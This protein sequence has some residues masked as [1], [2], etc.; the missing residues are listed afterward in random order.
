MIITSLLLFNL[1]Y[2]LYLLYYIYI[3]EPISKYLLSYIICLFV[4]NV[5]A[6][7]IKG[8]GLISSLIYFFQYTAI[9]F[10]IQKFS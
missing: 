3:M 9:T 2:L 7:G 1:F 5:I 6:A 4:I 8:N 10:N